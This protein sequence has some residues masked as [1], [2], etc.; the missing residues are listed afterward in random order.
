[1]ALKCS[2]NN[3]Q[4]CLFFL[5]FLFLG[6]LQTL[7]PYS[8]LC[9]ANSFHFGVKFAIAVPIMVKDIPNKYVCDA[10]M[11]NFFIF[12]DLDYTTLLNM[13]RQQANLQILS[14]IHSW[15]LLYKSFSPLLVHLIL[16]LFENIY[17]IID[18]AS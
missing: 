6:V 13:G 7:K 11:T 15:S 3:M 8:I 18:T 2:N 17:S 9:L 14:Y 10:M 5:A 1:M 12:S 16:L 4:L